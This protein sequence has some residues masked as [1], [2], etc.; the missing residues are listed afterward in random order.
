MKAIS[1][2][3]LAYLLLGFTALGYQ[4][5]AE[6][7]LDD[8]A[9]SAGVTEAL[10]GE[11][12]SI[13]GGV[14]F[15]H[16]G[17][18]SESKA[19][20]FDGTGF[21]DIS[22]SIFTNLDDS[23]SISFWTKGGSALPAQTFMLEALGASDQR[24]LNIHLPWTDSRVYFD[25]GNAASY[26]RIERL[27]TEAE[28]KDTWHHWL[29]T[30]NK[31][32]GTMKIYL[33]GELWQSAGNRTLSLDPI[34]KVTVGR[35]Y[36][37]LL[38][39]LQ[40][41]NGEIT[42][43]D[44]PYFF[45]EKGKVL[46]E[47]WYNLSGNNVATLTNSEKFPWAADE[48][49]LLPA[50]EKATNVN[51]YGSR[52]RA[53]LTV[54]A[55]GEYTFYI[56]GDD[57]CELYLNKSGSSRLG[58]EMIAEVPGWTYFRQW[59]R[60]A[61][62]KSTTVTLNA[63]DKLYLEALHKE[64]GGA[65]HV[66][67]AWTTPL[68]SDITVIDGQYLEPFY[69]DL[70]EQKSTLSAQIIAANDLLVSS[71]ANVGLALGEFSEALRYNFQVDISLAQAVYDDSAVTGQD[72]AIAIDQ[73]ISKTAAFVGNRPTKLYGEIF[74]T[75]LSW[76]DYATYDK[77]FDENTAT[78]VD[79][80]FG[81]G[82]VGID[83]GAGNEVA[84][85]KLRYF[86]R[87]IRL[88]RMV[89]GRFEASNDGVNWDVLY[90]I[91]QKPSADWQEVELSSNTTAYQY[92]RY[93]APHGHTNIAEVEFYAYHT[94][95]LVLSLNKAQNF[96]FGGADQAVK[97][98]RADH[99]G[100]YPQFITYTLTRLPEFGVLKL[101]GQ[102]LNVGDSFTQQDINDGLL[103]FADDQSHNNDSFA[104]TI[105][106][107]T[108]GSLPESYFTI[109]LDSD[110]DGID[111]LSEIAG[112]TDWN[113]A[114]TD[115]DGATDKWELDNNSDPTLNIL[116]P[117]LNAIQGS[118]G[119]TASY[120]YDSPSSLSA[121]PFNRGPQEVKKVDNI[122]WRNHHWGK[123]VGSSQANFV[124]ARFDGYI[125][126]PTDGEYTFELVSDD[127]SRLYIEDAL[128]VNNDGAHSV[129]AIQ[130]KQT[131][132]AGLKKIRIDYFQAG[133]YHSCLLYW[134]GP[135]I[136]YE[137]VPSSHFYLSEPEHAAIADTADKDRDYLSDSLELQEGTDPNNPDSDNDK[138]LDGEEYHAHY[139]YKT[140]P[141]DTDTDGDNVS[142]Y[143]E[144][145]IYSSNPLIADFSGEEILIRE[146]NPA[147]FQNAV[148][149]FGTTDT[150]V[151]NQSIRGY[152]EYDFDLDSPG[153]FLLKTGVKQRLANSNRNKFNLV[154]YIDGHYIRKKTFDV[155]ELD[156]VA[157]VLPYLKAGPHKLKIFLD[158]VY[159]KTSLEI[160]SLQIV[161]RLGLASGQGDWVDNLL[162]RTCYIKNK[163]K[164]SY[165]SPVCIEGGG[166]YLH[167]M[168]INKG[169]IQRSAYEQWYA[170]V[171]L[172][173][174]ELTEVNVTWQNNAV[175]DQLKIS[176]LQTNVLCVNEMVVRQG[177]S[178]LLNAFLEDD[179][180]DLIS[181]VV[182][183]VDGLEFAVS[184][185]N[186]KKYKFSKAGDYT[187][188]ARYKNA[189]GEIINGSMTVKV[190]APV[191]MDTIY[192]WRFRERIIPKPIIDENI[193]IEG[194][195]FEFSYTEDNKMRLKRND[196]YEEM[197][198]TF[199]LGG[200]GPI[201]NTV[202][203]IGFWVQEI[204]EGY[205]IITETLS[206]GSQIVSDKVF[207]NP[208]FPEVLDINF[209]LLG[210]GLT[211]DDG[212]TTRTIRKDVFN[213]LGIHINEYY[214]DVTRSG[215]PCHRTKVY[216]NGTFIGERR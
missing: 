145:F 44:L 46:Y 151:Y 115:G 32:A 186:P 196:V 75:E 77:A 125:N 207:I 39:E 64:G 144:I 25:A 135:G 79:T 21:L 67:V 24:V 73:L 84:V 158:N 114:D 189:N 130:A 131:L 190:L 7:P 119:L 71:A 198:M 8:P 121:F 4:K 85:T 127:G 69:F 38:D 48:K 59:N 33:N 120:W 175:D 3:I 117:A 201:L 62:Q 53:F 146:L 14:T 216:Y 214:Q 142:D 147:N 49:E 42:P 56:S 152:L 94:P 187:I 153:L 107:V 66:S 70:A 96:V 173:Q 185:T 34:S 164:S 28:Y 180:Q 76:S 206:D 124:V 136:S 22:S 78:F 171:D 89:N 13:S 208:G 182:I 41:F 132:S 211:F 200:S 51:N 92:Y 126:I 210:G 176:W 15:N 148:G 27:A 160:T 60:Y 63:G 202:P 165:V 174:D 6:W 167:L 29:F 2:A 194:G 83:L 36:D 45:N 212:K 161:K 90:T 20:K 128:I 35:G 40:I 203:V 30:R 88:D 149:N 133:G 1:Y 109:T 137:L 26:N 91:T 150:S 98:L 177:D 104:F 154:F 215:G 31:E 138:L 103:T 209:Y 118:N 183:T 195:G 72:V 106:D 87:V 81:S 141:L 9:N 178:L 50:F 5:I 52:L 43:A 10:N 122:S 192:L 65:D 11:V 170:N 157:V 179:G 134:K 181:D 55:T 74:G 110:N 99:S 188:K 143:D 17:Y 166:R 155:T 18:T 191:A 58:K 16:E 102:L 105:A 168:T 140:N 112:N 111:D 47:R 205:Y 37:G 19:V 172:V 213:E 95:S 193:N 108:G 82:H 162:N 68:S 113:N 163:V 184:L 197:S 93:F 100:L 57:E 86:P 12:G 204:V 116:S 61:A 156:N 54:P 23:F 123:A 199:R 129:R 101:N 80:M 169:T 139:N 97:T 159:E